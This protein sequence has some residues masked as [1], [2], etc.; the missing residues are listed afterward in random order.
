MVFF[1]GTY[2]VYKGH[3]TEED[4]NKLKKVLK[5]LSYTKSLTMR[6]GE[7]GSNVGLTVYC[8]ASF[9]TCENAK[10]F[11]GIF[12]TGG[13]GMIYCKCGK[14]KLVARSSTESELIV[15]SDAAS[16]LLWSQQFLKYQGYNVQGELMEDNM[17]T[18]SMMQNGR[19]MSDR[20]RHVD[21][22]YFFV[23]QYIV[24]GKI[25]LKYCPTAIMVADILT[26]PLQGFHFERLRDL[27][28]GHSNFF[29]SYEEYGT[30]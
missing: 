1:E 20:T 8:D 29:R 9:A 25:V 19:S 16:I 18:I 27:L 22:K 21:V 14:L 17:S 28:L 5:Y 30:T 6:I 3:T 13:N 2:T 23:K 4:L 15:L 11:G 24:N 10:S 7:A 26:K 12:V